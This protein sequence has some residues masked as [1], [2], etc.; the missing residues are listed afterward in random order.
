MQGK[1]HLMLGKIMVDN[2]PLSPIKRWLFLLG[3]VEPDINFLTYTRGSIKFRFLHGHNADNV[4]G[5]LSRI[6][7]RLENSG[8]NTLFQWFTLGTTVHYIADSFTFAHNEF[9]KGDLKEHME[10]ER[11]LHIA[12]EKYLNEMSFKNIKYT[13]FKKYH[14][15]YVNDTRSFIT[16]CRYITTA[17]LGLLEYV[18]AGVPDI[19]GIIKFPVV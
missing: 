4:E 5:H 2:M 7:D 10:Y 15:Q 18:T 13:D 12:F 14:E 16:D 8:V 3:C 11:L 19:C 17:A 6:I 9:F 1:D